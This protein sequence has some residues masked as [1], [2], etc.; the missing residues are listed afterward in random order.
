M[1]SLVLLE[2]QQTS[3]YFAKVLFYILVNYLVSQSAN[4]TQSVG[5]KKKHR[6]A[7]MRVFGRIPSISDALEHLTRN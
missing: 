5:L 3:V 6:A 1:L 4:G 7:H 2:N